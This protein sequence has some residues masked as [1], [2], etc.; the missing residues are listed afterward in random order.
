MPANPSLMSLHLK[1]RLVIAE[2]NFDINVLRIFGD[3]LTEL[4]TKRKEPEV[5]AKSDHFEKEFYA[6]RTEIDDIRHEMQLVKMKLGAFSRETQPF[7]FKIFNKESHS[8]L[9]K[10]LLAYK[11]RFKKINKEFEEFEG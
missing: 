10:R 8:P 7:D 5:R 11:N 2:L 6:L 4:R 1:Y 3:Y 9:R